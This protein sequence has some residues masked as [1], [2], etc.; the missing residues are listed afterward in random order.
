MQEREAERATQGH[1]C[2]ITAVCTHRHTYTCTHRH[3]Y[4]RAHTR[5]RRDTHMYIYTYVCTQ[6]H[7]C[8]HTH[9]HVQTRVCTHIHMH[10]YMHTGTCIYTRGCTHTYTYVDEHTH[11]HTLWPISSLC[12]SLWPWAP[13]PRGCSLWSLGSGTPR[14]WSVTTK[15][16]PLSKS[17][18]ALNP[19]SSAPQGLLQDDLICPDVQALLQ[20]VTGPQRVIRCH[21][22]GGG[23]QAVREKGV[24]GPRGPRLPS[25]EWR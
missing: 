17:L 22:V 25:G 5:A 3:T 13:G 12:S 21:S 18:P 6:T 24:T 1:L 20:T 23:E 7:V 8:M 2:L 19:V 11:T 14:F 9:L 16:C 15:L 10:M 4:T